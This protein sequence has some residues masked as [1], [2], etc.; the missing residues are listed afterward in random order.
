MTT[1]QG[2]SEV[3]RH[4]VAVLRLGRVF[5]MV[6]VSTFVRLQMT[7]YLRAHSGEPSLLTCRLESSGRKH[8]RISG[9]AGLPHKRA[10]KG[11]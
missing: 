4:S 7:S 9:S 1:F 2:P 3:S 10:L 8:R 5:L 6:W 11:V